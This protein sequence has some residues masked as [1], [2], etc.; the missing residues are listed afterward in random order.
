[1]DTIKQKELDKFFNKVHQ[2]LIKNIANLY[3]LKWRWAD[4]KDHEDFED[5]KKVII[6]LAKKSG[7]T[8]YKISKSFKISFK[9]SSNIF[10][11]IY[12]KTNAITKIEYTKQN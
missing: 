1:M 7:L 12:L 3:S 9:F 11:N 10:V 8:P 2:F 5:Y 6:N 4:E